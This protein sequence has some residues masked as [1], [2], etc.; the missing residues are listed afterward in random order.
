[1]HDFFNMRGPHLK[2]LTG[3]RGGLNLGFD[4][5]KKYVQK[6]DNF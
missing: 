5:N 2:T 1:M 4:L 6:N 3:G